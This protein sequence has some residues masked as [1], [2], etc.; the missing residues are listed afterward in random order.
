MRSNTSP[1][2]WALVLIVLGILATVACLIL[3][4]VT[5]VSALRYGVAGGSFVQFLGWVRH[6]RYLRH[7]RGGAR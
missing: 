2:G 7:L 4:P 1:R 5:D 6:G 3:A